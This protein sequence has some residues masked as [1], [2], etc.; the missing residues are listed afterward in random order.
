MEV[1]NV[2][3]NKKIVIVAAMTGGTQQ[4]REGA[5]VPTTPKEIAEEAYK[6]Y[7]A[8]ATAIHIHARDENKVATGDVKVFQE[9][10]TRIRDK[11]DILIQTTNGIGSRHDPVT[12]AI[13]RPTE[14]ERLA[15]LKLK[16][17]QDLFSIA[18][19]SWDFYHPGVP[20]QNQFSFLNTVEF[21]KKIVPAVHAVGSSIEFEITQVSFFDR[22][23]RLADEG[24]FDPNGG[25]Y[26][27][28]YCFGFGGMPSTARAFAF[29]LD[30]GQ[31][32][33]PT[34]KWQ[35]TA[36]DKSMFR[37]N[38]MGLLQDCDIV[39]VGFEDNIY[40]PNGEPAQHNHQQVEAMVRI[41]REFG[42]EAATVA[43]A[44]QVFGL[45]Q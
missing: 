25:R 6:C 33:F 9:I 20:N 32:A 37:M 7:Q 19:G 15:L 38:T 41:A 10:I 13:I 35:V 22:L 29:A 45:K 40:L 30:E 16:P 36:T 23:R 4:D 39:R 42:R 17:G 2:M 21:L 44:R 27:L 11:C 5:K 14:A 34:A 3:A 43:E 26:W 18:G 28:N 8:G 24:V 12:G 1:G 31:R